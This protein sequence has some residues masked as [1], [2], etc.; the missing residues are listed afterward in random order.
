MMAYRRLRGELLQHLPFMSDLARETHPFVV[1]QKSAQVGISELL[2]S[3]AL[4]AAAV[5]FAGRGHVMLLHPTQ[6]LMDAFTQ[7]RI[8]TAIQDSAYIRTMLQPEPPRRRGVDSLQVKRINDGHLMLR[9]SESRRQIASFDADWVMLDEADQMDEEV[10]ALARSRLGSSRNGR[11]WAISTPSYPEGGINAWFRQSDQREYHIPCPPCGLRQPLRWPENIDLERGLRVCRDC[12]SELDVLMEG[13]WVAAAPGNDGIRG[14]RVSRLYSPWCDIPAMVE[15]SEATTPV[16]VQQFHNADLGQ[17]FSPPGGGLSAEDLDRCRRQYSLADYRGEPCDVGIDVGLRLHVVVR[18]HPDE[19][20]RGDAAPQ[21]RLWFA[22]D[23]EWAELE[24]VLA[25]FKVRQI[26]IDPHPE[27][28]KAREFAQAHEAW[29]VY[30]TRHEA[31]VT[32]T[33]KTNTEPGALHTNR[34]EMLDTVM[35]QFRDGV[36]E[37]PRDARELGGRVRAR[38]G[39]GEYYREILA[40]QRIVESDG[41]GNPVARWDDHN[42]DDHYAHAEVYC[43]LAS[44]HLIAGHIGRIQTID[45]R[46]DPNRREGWGHWI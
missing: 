20:S 5:R 8:N 41:Y 27:L 22:G 1:I 14:Y 40:P 16:A 31:G 44:W 42:R 2:V 29:L 45:L 32:K 15:A 7:T 35:Q 11:L 46:P 23:V 12:H 3:L 39:Y 37:L 21:R 33:K 25:R 43:L 34:T 36:A 24:S 13:Q 19:S 38:E 26:A 10:Y 28:A 18:Q 4:W 6:A 30:Y 17:P 9:G